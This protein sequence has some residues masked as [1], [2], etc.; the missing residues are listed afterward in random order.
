MLVSSTG[1]AITSLAFGFTFD[2]NW[3]CVTRF[4]Q[5]CFLGK[6]TFVGLFQYDNNKFQ[7]RLQIT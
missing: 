6:N 7:R 5:G 4:L 3:A 1:M 2:Y